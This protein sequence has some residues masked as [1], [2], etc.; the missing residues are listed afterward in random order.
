MKALFKPLLV[1]AFATA[2]FSSCMKDTSAEDEAAQRELEA[3][4]HAQ[5][6]ADAEEIKQFREENLSEAPG[7]WQEDDTDFQFPALGKTI[8]RGFWF[9]LINDPDLDEDETYEYKLT[10]D[11]RNI[12]LPKIKVT[13]SVSL[14]DG[15]VV[16]SGENKE[17]DLA[18]FTSNSDV[19][20]SV[21]YF[22]FIPEIIEYNTDEIPANGLTERG[23]QKGS[24]IRVLAPS[25]F[26]FGDKKN[27]DIPANSP[28]VY[29]FEVL[30]II[31]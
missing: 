19:F 14:L 20:N 28:L 18:T 23:L 3:K 24:H 30:D 17:I 11:L 27:G 6:E 21:W 16:Q 22:S 4:I 15:E 25:Y 2:A 26:A 10:Q 12:A 8:K 31:E 13:Y 9:E 5:F 1:L 29:E 7:G